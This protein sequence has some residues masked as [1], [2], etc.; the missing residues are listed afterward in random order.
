MREYLEERILHRFVRIVRVAQI[1]IRDTQ[2]ASLMVRHQIR[3]AVARR[4]AVA[5]EHQRLDC[6]R[7]L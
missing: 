4:L 7:Y 3:E 6:R 1:V 2:R 5:N